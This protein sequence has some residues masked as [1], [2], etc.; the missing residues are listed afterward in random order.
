MTKVYRFYLITEDAGVEGTDNEEI[1]NAAKADGY[2]VV[3]ETSTGK[4]FF[5]STEAFVSA[6]DKA[7]WI[8]PTEAE[9]AE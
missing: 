4:Y 8:E 5:D 6:A 2:T 3:L 9:D 7:D 1:A